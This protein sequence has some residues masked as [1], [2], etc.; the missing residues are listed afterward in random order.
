M[1]YAEA[2]MPK[3]RQRQDV[4]FAGALTPELPITIGL[5][6]AGAL[7]PGIKKLL[8]YVDNCHK[9]ASESRVF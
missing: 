8:E 6:V 4:A 5:A 1:H 3:S 2:R 7:T 9:G